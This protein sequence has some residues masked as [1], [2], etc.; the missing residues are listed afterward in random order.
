[1]WRRWIIPGLFILPI[2]LCASG[3]VTSTKHFYSIRYCHNGYYVAGDVTW[4]SITLQCS[5]DSGLS[6]GWRCEALPQAHARF[7]P[8]RADPEN[9][10]YFGFGL[11]RDVYLGHHAYILCLPCW[12][13]IV[14]SSAVLYIVWRKTHPSK[15]GGPSRSR[16]GESL[17]KR[18]I[19]RGVF[20]WLLLLCVAGWVGSYACSF[21]IYHNVRD[22][23]WGIGI[24]DGMVL[25]GRAGEDWWGWR[26]SGVV[27]CSMDRSVVV[28][29][30]YDWN[31]SR[32]LGFGYGGGTNILYERFWCI[33]FWFPTILAAV[34]SF[35]VW[36]KTRPKI[37][38]VT[39]FPVEVVNPK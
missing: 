11:N 6:N 2:L 37:N 29:D 23:P 16:L 14:I 25:L 3:W 26:R 17:I 28:H 5:G 24:G 19:I 32:F 31:P 21:G 30:K 34:A 13:V 20:L 38:P 1:M 27:G 22:C 12:F 8:M 7:W 39:A 35:I 33:P 18:W 10:V 15:P 4:G 9:H 36:R